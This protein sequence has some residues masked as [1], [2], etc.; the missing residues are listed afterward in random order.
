MIE[1]GRLVFKKLKDNH[2]QNELNALNEIGRNNLIYYRNKFGTMD[3]CPYVSYEQF[4]DTYTFKKDGISF[5]I[6]ST[7]LYIACLE[8]SNGLCSPFNIR[9]Y[10]FLLFYIK[11]G[12]QDTIK[13]QIIQKGTLLFNIIYPFEDEIK[14]G[15]YVEFS[16]N[17]EYGEFIV[18]KKY[19][20][21]SFYLKNWEIY[22]K[23]NYSKIQPMKLIS[24]I[25]QKQSRI[26]K[27]KQL[28]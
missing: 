6:L 25:T 28:I 11:C 2:T 20:I 19:E 5:D 15:N 12:L 21:V 26:L 16:S 8:L 4:N 10:D 17:S 14:T 7:D 9:I 1:T 24:C 3:N 23:D 18:G 13:Y 22:V 27:L